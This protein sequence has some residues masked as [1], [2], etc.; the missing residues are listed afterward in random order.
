[1]SPKKT[2]HLSVEEMLLD[3]G[4]IVDKEMVHL[5]KLDLDGLRVIVTQHYR[6]A[7]EKAS[8]SYLIESIGKSIRTEVTSI[9]KEGPKKKDLKREDKIVIDDADDI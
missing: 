9:L 5:S 1:M 3:V 2:P 7:I 8:R 4:E 6:S